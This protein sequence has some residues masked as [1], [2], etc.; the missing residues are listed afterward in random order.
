MNSEEKCK[1]EESCGTIKF[2]KPSNVITGTELQHSGKSSKSRKSSKKEK[3]KRA[4]HK[5]K[6]IERPKEKDLQKITLKTDKDYK[7]SS[8]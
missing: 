4:S 3:R 2:G 1:I 6:D 8:S 5:E 7:V